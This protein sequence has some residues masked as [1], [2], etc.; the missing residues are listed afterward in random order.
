MNRPWRIGLGI[1]L[2]F[3]G[4]GLPLVT[5]VAAYLLPPTYSAK[6]VI[7]VE[8]GSHAPWPRAMDEI[9][10]IG[11][12][13]VLE[14]V[15]SELNL[16]VEWGKRF[17]Q[18]APLPRDLTRRLLRKSVSVR[19]LQNSTL[20]DIIVTSAN[21]G[22]AAV[23]ANRIA[24]VYRRCVAQEGRPDGKSVSI[25]ERAEPVPRPIRPNKP[26]MIVLGTAFGFVLV[27]LGVL[28][29]LSSRRRSRMLS[30]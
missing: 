18:S 4:T 9:G 26:L 1:F 25:I 2:I 11:S 22:E 20:L 10:S 19:Q 7:S 5:T 24:D 28:S 16:S 30:G 23:I 15:A 17:K 3:L 13:T 8:V 29:A 6:T 27:A 14:Q 21:P 12:T